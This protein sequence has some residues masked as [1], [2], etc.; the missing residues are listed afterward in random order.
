MTERTSRI[1]DMLIIPEPIKRHGHLLFWDAPYDSNMA[2]G[3]IHRDHGPCLLY[4]SGAIY[5]LYESTLEK[6]S[7]ESEDRPWKKIHEYK[8][9]GDVI[10]IFANSINADGIALIN[11]E[12]DRRPGNNADQKFVVAGKE[13][14]VITFR[15]DD[16]TIITYQSLLGNTTLN[17]STP[18]LFS[19]R[20]EV[21]EYVEFKMDQ[22]GELLAETREQL[23]ELRKHV[24]KYADTI[25][26][27]NLRSAGY[28]LNEYK[29]GP[30]WPSGWGPGWP[31][32]WPKNQC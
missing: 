14:S 12:P 28:N 3:Y 10:E 26:K 9:S 21:F 4:L 30:G 24:S 18:S 29:D 19:Q 1:G 22:N 2:I 20:E 11:N 7:K 31:P 6:M 32:G 25:R 27:S 16:E 17:V 23:E 8:Q 13:I 5:L 15:T